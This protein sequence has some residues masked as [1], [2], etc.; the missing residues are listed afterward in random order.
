MQLENILVSYIDD[1][2]FA[3]PLPLISRTFPRDASPTDKKEKKIEHA[4]ETH[5]SALESDPRIFLRIVAVPLGTIPPLP[6]LSR[7]ATRG[8]ASEGQISPLN[9]QI[10][11]K[12]RQISGESGI[13]QN[14]RKQP[15]GWK[16]SVLDE[17]FMGLVQYTRS[18][19]KR[20]CAPL[21]T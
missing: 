13:N 6:R 3:T 5:N 9:A 21:P 7:T 12:G 15:R 1:G 11:D 4:A 16:R 17:G 10:K 8:V 14:I 19:Q 2:G 20:G 18:T